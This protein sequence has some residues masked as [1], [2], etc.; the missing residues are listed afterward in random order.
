MKE[1]I[2][3]GV[4][5]AECEYYKGKC[6]EYTHYCQIGCKECT[7]IGIKLCHYKQTERFKAQIARLEQENEKLKKQ[8]ENFKKMFEEQFEYKEI[9]LKKI[10][11]LKEELA[12]LQQEN[13]DIA[14]ARMEICNQ[15]GEKDDYNIPCKMIRDLDYGLTVTIEER[16][17]YKQTL[18]EIRDI[19]DKV[20]I[21]GC[22]CIDKRN[23][24][25]KVNDLLGE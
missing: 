15:C 9:N 19:A 16:D 13:E 8:V 10:E 20:C 5:V 6:M 3:D 11:K 12:I 7:D 23:I 22:K 4:N 25:N 2:I 17:R 24:L 21:S 1:I 18:E 14:E